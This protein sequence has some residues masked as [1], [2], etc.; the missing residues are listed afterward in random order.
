M[1][2]GH[3]EIVEGC[4]ADV[5]FLVTKVKC[6]TLS[7]ILAIFHYLKRNVFYYIHNFLQFG[8]TIG[9]FVITV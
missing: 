1:D 2:N 8:T 6:F 9:V 3:F 7:N 4:W 5:N